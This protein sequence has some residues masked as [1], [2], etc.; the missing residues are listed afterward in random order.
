MTNLELVK[1]TIEYYT[2]D[3]SRRGIDDNGSCVYKTKDE[4]KCAVGRWIDEDKC[5]E[6]N[7]EIERLEGDVGILCNILN[8]RFS[9]NLEDI[10]IDDVK[11]IPQE[12]WMDLQMYHDTQIYW[13]D[14]KLRK[15]KEEFLLNK[16]K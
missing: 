7:I 3:P 2:D 1:N 8:K 10:L 6:Y 12:L 15:E 13:K 4:K 16:W 5:K 14:E 11:D 9:L